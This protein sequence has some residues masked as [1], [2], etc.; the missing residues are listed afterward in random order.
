[1]LFYTAVVG[2][3]LV[4][5]LISVVITIPKVADRWKG[6]YRLAIG[7][8]VSLLAAF[9]LSAI[10]LTTGTDIIRPGWI[11]IVL[12][13]ALFLVALELILVPYIHRL[14]AALKDDPDSLRGKE[15]A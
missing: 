7:P 12:Q 13:L 15:G 1:M 14:E 4:A 2:L 8:A 6:A 10:R 3:T 5:G 11:L 9:V